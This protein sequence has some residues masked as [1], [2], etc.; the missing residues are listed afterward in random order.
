MNAKRFVWLTAGILSFLAI[1]IYALILLLPENCYMDDEYPNWLEQRDHVFTDDTKQEILLLGDSRMKMG[2]MPTEMGDNVYNLALGGGSPIEMYYTLK[3][4][5]QHHPHP[6]A[7][8]LGFGPT[9]FTQMKSYAG[10]TLYFH[11][12]DDKTVNDINKT[13]KD[14]DGVDFHTE[15]WAYKYHWPN[16]YMRPVLKSI[17]K[18]R[19][20][21]NAAL[22]QQAREAKGRLIKNDKSE[23]QYI[24]T[25]ESKDGPFAP[26]KS[27]T[28]YTEQILAL[29]NDNNIPVY[30]EQLPMGNPGY[31]RLIDSGYMADYHAYLRQMQEKYAVN[32]YYDIPLYEPYYFQDEHHLNRKG[33]LRYSNELKERY[34]FIF[35]K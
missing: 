23:E 1:G 19:E 30:M 18:P 26:L 35:N 28:Y 2:A 22:Y 24:V 20:E 9:H 3:N 14:L 27:L 8:I 4:Y 16:V 17:F 6:K 5:L 33:A 21:K 15:Y 32:I 13:V 7:V 25:P 11:Y 34:P 10:R 29:C 12:F 31:Q